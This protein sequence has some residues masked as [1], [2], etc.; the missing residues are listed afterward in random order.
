MK[1]T[2][3]K[4]EPEMRYNECE[5]TIFSGKKRICE[6][7]S[8]DGDKFNDPPLKEAEANAKLIAAAPEMLSVLQT[9]LKHVNG[10]SMSGHEE[11]E[12]WASIAPAIK[13]SNRIIVYLQSI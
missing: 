8:F 2:K 7:K 4:W 10:E 9:L 12:M 13:K 6:V 1:H 5:L 3:G 11:I